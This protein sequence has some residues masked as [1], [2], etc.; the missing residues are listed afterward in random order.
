MSKR[1]FVEI[2]IENGCIFPKVE[3][4]TSS[5]KVCGSLSGVNIVYLIDWRDLTAGLFLPPEAGGEDSG[6][7][8]S[9]GLLSDPEDFEEDESVD[10]EGLKDKGDFCCTCV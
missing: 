3:K 8:I 1:Q 9:T 5:T 6:L 4:F 7:N 2:S 10:G